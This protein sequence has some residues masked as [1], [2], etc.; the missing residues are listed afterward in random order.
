MQNTQLLKFFIILHFIIVSNVSFAKTSYTQN[1]LTNEAKHTINYLSQKYANQRNLST[2][3]LIIK[4]ALEFLDKPYVGNT[5]EI[6]KKENIILNL[7]QFDCTTFAENCL[8]ISRVIKSKSKTKNLKTFKKELTT[9]RYRNGNLK[10][11]TSRLHYFSDW[12][13]D[14]EQKKIVKNISCELGAF[15]FNNYVDYMSVNSAKYK[16]LA[17]KSKDIYKTKIIEDKISKR[18]SC[19][20]P[21]N[22]LVK[23]EHE[24]LDGDIIGITTK[25]PGM[26]MAHVVLAYHQ[27]GQ[28]HIIHASL[29][30]KKVVISN[31]TLQEYLMNREDATG[32]MVARP[33]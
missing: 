27:N 33:I 31:E 16:M 15:A 4:V 12:I 6:N 3:E 19:Y 22:E 24:I 11:Y 2:G 14:N 10:G 13:Y 17:N 21:K 26:D 7:S 8:A 29:K 25:I 28:L 18:N 20:I 23:Y 5:L 30:H 1:E 32:I 9:I